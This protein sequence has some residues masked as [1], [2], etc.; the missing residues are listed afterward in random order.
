MKSEKSAIKIQN[1]HKVDNVIQIS[2]FK[3]SD[4]I[5]FSYRGEKK[6]GQSTL[7]WM[8]DVNNTSFNVCGILDIFPYPS[9]E[10]TIIIIAH[11]DVLSSIFQ[12][13]TYEVKDFSLVLDANADRA[14]VKEQLLEYIRKDS[15]PYIYDAEKES[16]ERARE[17]TLI[18][19]M[20]FLYILIT[21]IVVLSIINTLKINLLVRSREIGIQRAIGMD[22]FQL[23][24]SL[25]AEGFIYGIVSS[26]VGLFF[27]AGIITTFYYQQPLLYRI[28][29]FQMP[30]WQ[31]ASGF[32]G[33]LILCMAATLPSLKNM[34]KERIVKL[35][36]AQ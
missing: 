35:I 2:D 26:L 4:S 21:I 9:G 30:G 8:S 13:D 33:I 12:D 20:N 3:V 18:L 15:N 6:P 31:I 1:M 17:E 5:V 19:I 27:S 16:E 10:G 7:D 36:Y 32:F 23:V 24:G 28:N 11:K 22:T 14:F 25:L 34:V 29:P